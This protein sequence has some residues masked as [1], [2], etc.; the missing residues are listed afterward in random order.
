MYGK[1]YQN[2]HPDINVQA[3]VTFG[4]LAITILLGLVGVLNGQLYYWVF[5]TAIRLWVC[6]FLNAHIYY[7]GRL[8]VDMGVFRRMMMVCKCYS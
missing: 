3:P 6:L 8:K 5:F 1:I 2:R 7:M 4:V